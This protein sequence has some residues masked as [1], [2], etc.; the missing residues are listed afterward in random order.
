MI[1]RKAAEKDIDGV[2]KVYSD[3]HT[4]EEE[5]RVVIGWIRGVYPTRDT[6]LAALSRG[7]L[8]VMETED[9]IVGTAIINQSQVDIY[10]KGNWQFDAPDNEVMVLHT[11]VISPKASGKGYGRQF[12]EYYERYAASH[13]C[14]YLRMDTNK[15]N[16]TARK[17]YSKLGYREIGIEQ[18]DF[19]G[20]KGV[21]LVLLEKKLP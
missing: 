19:N 21:S 3:T 17:M 12:V 10:E 5:G 2:E 7:D 4:A 8:F 15:I 1:I 9:G 11:L 16:S 18:G 20:I 13:G 6:V 14:R